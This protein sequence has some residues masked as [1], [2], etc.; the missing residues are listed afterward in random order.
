MNN[1]YDLINGGA[2]HVALQP[3]NLATAAVSGSYA[4]MSQVKRLVILIFAAAGTASEP[5]VVSLTQATSG[6]GDGAK[7]CN[8]A[9]IKSLEAAD[10]TAS[11]AW[12]TVAAVDR[13]NTVASYTATQATATNQ[14]ALYI[15]VDQADLD[16]ANGFTH[17]RANIADTGSGARLGSIVYIA[18]EK[19][20]QGENLP[21]LLS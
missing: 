3:V 5:L 7:A 8:L 2:L 17:V 19:F 6:A 4:N 16:L 10:I 20:Y 1:N 12:T 11:Q 9:Y 18:V 21:G 14:I 15:E 13:Q